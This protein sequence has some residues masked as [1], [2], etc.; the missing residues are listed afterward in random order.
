MSDTDKALFEPWHRR[1]GRAEFLRPRLLISL[2]R[3]YIVVY[4]VGVAFLYAFSLIAP[5]LSLRYDPSDLP[6]SEVL[7]VAFWWANFVVGFM[8]IEVPIIYIL[9]PRRRISFFKPKRDENETKA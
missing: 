7:E 8:V 4:L 2:A 1:F 5:H 6:P 9:G 3:V